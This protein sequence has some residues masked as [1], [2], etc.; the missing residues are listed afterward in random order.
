MGDPALRGR[1]RGNVRNVLVLR[2]GPGVTGRASVQSVGKLEPRLTASVS[3]LKFCR[4]AGVR[5]R[6]H[7]GLT[8]NGVRSI[9]GFNVVDTNRSQDTRRPFWR[10]SDAHPLSDSR[11]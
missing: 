10:A 3:A 8:T 7:S 9:G 11:T 4:Q 2:K 6:I 1:R 5:V